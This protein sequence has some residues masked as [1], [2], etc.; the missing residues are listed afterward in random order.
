MQAIFCGSE[1]V[2]SHPSLFWLD[3]NTL[4]TW[5]DSP[6]TAAF[7]KARLARTRSTPCL[8]QLHLLISSL[9]DDWMIVI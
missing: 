7:I 2:C 3:A 4:M 8:P 6:S 5:M 1:Q 9:P